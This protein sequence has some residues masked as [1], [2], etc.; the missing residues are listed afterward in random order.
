VLMS[1]TSV[2]VI[3]W[4]NRS[5]AQRSLWR[6]AVAP[7]LGLAGLVVAAVAIGANF[8]MLVGDVDAAGTPRWGA[9]SLGLVGLV[10]LLPAIGWAQGTVM[11]KARPRSYAR[12]TESLR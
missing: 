7:S 1:V 11:K 9:L 3:V 2:A 10:V 6:T 5:P 4:F 8:P 12:L